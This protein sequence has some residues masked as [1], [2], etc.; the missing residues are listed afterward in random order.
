MPPSV[1]S[2]DA[3][4]I[5]E[6]AEVLRSAVA[7]VDTVRVVNKSEL[8]RL[9]DSAAANGLSCDASTVDCAARLGAY[10]GLDFALVS[11]VISRDVDAAAVVV[12]RQATLALVDCASG[13]AVRTVDAP[14][15]AT[16][17]EEQAGL[18]ALVVAVLGT[19]AVSGILEVTT[20]S[21]GGASAGGDAVNVVDVIVD[22]TARGPA[23]LRLDLPAGPHLVARAGGRDRA[24][25]V[26]AAAIV[27]VDVAELEG[28]EGRGGTG[29]LEGREGN[30]R[31]PALT[32][33]VAAGVAIVAVTTAAATGLGAWSVAPDRNDRGS[34]SARGYNDAVATGQLLLI[35]S[36]AAVVV[37][38]AAGVVWWVSDG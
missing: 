37:A 12:P 14:L 38:G 32:G 21:D 10:G 19:G 13:R 16:A 27:V 35:A 26:P 33:P 23:P 30:A 36:A 31:A 4:D 1:A 11:R 2:A 5:A 8:A 15:G 7:D 17:A 24:V 28:L 22:G 6:V 34:Y 29:G 18:R 3:A 25:I 9:I 20:R